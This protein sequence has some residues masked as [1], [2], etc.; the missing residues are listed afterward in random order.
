MKKKRKKRISNSARR[1]N[2]KTEFTARVSADSRLGAPR[3]RIAKIPSTPFFRFSS[4]SGRVWCRRIAI[5]VEEWR[6]DGKDT[7][8]VVAVTTAWRRGVHRAGP[9]R[10]EGNSGPAHLRAG[11]PA[12]KH[13]WPRPVHLVNR[14]GSGRTGLFHYFL[15][16]F[17][18]FLTYFGQTHTQLSVECI[19]AGLAWASGF[20][21]LNPSPDHL[22]IGLILRPKPSWKRAGLSFGPAQTINTLACSAWSES[23]K[24]PT[25]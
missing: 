6:W 11:R 4:F 3:P 14:V 24:G 17:Q 25:I 13:P 5:W 18:N 10:K 22:L 1:T 2:A 9:D 19:Q 21:L 7:E 8:N 12:L 23:P 15:I 20:L 16:F